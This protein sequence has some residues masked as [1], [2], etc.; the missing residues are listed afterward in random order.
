MLTGGSDAGRD[1]GIHANGRE[2]SN[3]GDGYSCGEAVH[4]GRVELWSV[5]CMVECQ[6]SNAKDRCASVRQ[7]VALHLSFYVC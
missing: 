6:M 1:K 2:K 7:C 3:R 5:F 4:G